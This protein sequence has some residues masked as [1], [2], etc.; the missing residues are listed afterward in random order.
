M[1]VSEPPWL[2]PASVTVYRKSP[3]ASVASAPPWNLKL[4][5]GR[6]CV[7]V[8]GPSSEDDR[9]RGRLADDRH[10]PQPGDAAAV[11]RVVA[12]TCSPGARAS[13]SWSG[14]CGVIAARPRRIGVASFWPMKPVPLK[15][16]WGV[17]SG[18]PRND[19]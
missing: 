5:V 4:P 1:P 9:V 18:A 11:G 19:W 3:C 7:V 2:R 10:R 14:T 17:K 8:V 13:V 15:S 6:G 12:G 16:Y